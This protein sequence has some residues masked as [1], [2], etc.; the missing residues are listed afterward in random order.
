MQTF[1]LAFYLICF[2]AALNAQGQI[3]IQGMVVDS[4]TLDPL[5]ETTVNLKHS[6]KGTITDAQGFFT[7]ISANFDTLVFSR[8]G[9]QVQVYPFL[10]SET[11]VMFLLRE[12]VKVLKEVVVDFYSEDKVVHSAPRQ[13]RTLSAGEAVTSPFTYFSKTEKEKRMLVRLQEQQQKVQ[14]FLDLIIQPQFKAE[15]M[16]KFAINEETYYDIL[17]L[18]NTQ[19]R[20][21]HYLKDE[22]EITKRVMHF[23]AIQVPKN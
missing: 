17:V 2:I 11:D 13:V 21:A 15:V 10:N 8:I 4:V 18:F 1:R 22:S 6:K 19:N 16:D 23:F 12:E 5:P 7:I 3:V 20:D 9:Y 14:V